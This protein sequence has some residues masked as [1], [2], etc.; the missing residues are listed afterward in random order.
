MVPHRKLPAKFGGLLSEEQ[1][2]EIEELG[3]LAD[4]DDQV[5]LCRRPV[6]LLL[7]CIECAQTVHRGKNWCMIKSSACQCVYV[8][9]PL[10]Q[11]ALCALR[12][13]VRAAHLDSVTAWRHPGS[14]FGLF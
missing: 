13:T 9:V 5:R 8:Q 6:M 1:L 4:L 7:T 10:S 14:F 11:L 2:K 12:G 3:L